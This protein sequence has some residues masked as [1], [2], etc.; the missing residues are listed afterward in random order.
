M[1]RGCFDLH[2]RRARTIAGGR[3][4]DKFWASIAAYDVVWPQSIPHTASHLLQNRIAGEMAMGVIDFLEVI[5]VHQ[6]D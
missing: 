5:E 6:D 3:S 1:P 2:D 4:E